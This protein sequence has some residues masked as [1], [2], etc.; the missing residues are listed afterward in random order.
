[1]KLDEVLAWLEELAHRF[2]DQPR[3]S[4]DRDADEE[5]M[6]EWATEV[7]SA[8]RS[9]LPD[10]HIIIRD[11]NK[12]MSDI[13]A[14][15]YVADVVHSS[16]VMG[17]LNAAISMIKKGRLGSLVDSIRAETESE[18]LDQA[19]LL[20]S[21]DF[22]PA[23]AVIAGGALET[24]LR[25]YITNRSL[26]VTGSGSISA[27]NGAVGQ[28]RKDDPNRHYSANE[29]KLVEAWGGIRND[30]AHSPGTFP[31]SKDRVAQM[32]AGIREFIA[33]NI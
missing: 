9:I 18:L 10:G 7:E 6:R 14:S 15:Q 19:E 21:R 29:G 1:M 20:L 16:G 3:M 11:W 23:G 33:R 2:D 31:H 17:V 5:P 27:Y 22:L 30:A 32:I 12:V 13:P 25:R 4:S 8:F 24:H 28:A 26:A